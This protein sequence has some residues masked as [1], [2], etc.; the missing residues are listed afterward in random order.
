MDR[1]TRRIQNT[2]QP[3]LDRDWETKTLE[4]LV[5]EFLDANPH[6]IRSGPSGVTSNGATGNVASTNRKI[7]LLHLI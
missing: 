3:S 5:N 2:K 1:D 6:F 7:D 4:S